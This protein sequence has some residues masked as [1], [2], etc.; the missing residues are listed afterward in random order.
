M[1]DNASITTVILGVAIVVAVFAGTCKYQ[2]EIT[3][4]K[5]IEAGLCQQWVATRGAWIWGSCY[6]Q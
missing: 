3:N 1:N 6:V 2:D 4:R 5:A